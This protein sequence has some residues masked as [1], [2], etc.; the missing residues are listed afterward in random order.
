LTIVFSVLRIMASSYAFSIFKF[1]FRE[2]HL[3]QTMP[4]L[5]PWGLLFLLWYSNQQIKNT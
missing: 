4:F 3:K 5:T 1:S 2:E